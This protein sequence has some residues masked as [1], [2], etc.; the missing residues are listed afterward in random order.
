M[1]SVEYTSLV[2]KVNVARKIC[3]NVPLHSCNT[4]IQE[5]KLKSYILL[6]H[7]VIEEYIESIALRIAGEAISK[8]ANESTITTALVGLI[9]SGIIG[10]I[11]EDGISRKLKR[12]PFE[13]IHLFA[14]TAYGRFRSIVDGNNG[15]KR[16]DQLKIFLPIGVDPE[17]EDPVTMAALDSFGT[18]R[19]AVAHQFKITK[20]HTLSEIESDLSTIVFG[21]QSFDDACLRN[22]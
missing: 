8:L 17:T 10:R 3:Y 4:E 21:L 7:A 18:K 12:E 16:D 19:G 5:L 13:D 2:Q 6:S 15:I 14:S 11:D 20:A 9:A 1:P 22:V